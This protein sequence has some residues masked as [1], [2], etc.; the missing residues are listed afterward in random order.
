MNPAQAPHS[1]PI[2]LLDQSPAQ[3]HPAFLL[4]SHRWE[5]ERQGT[6]TL[7]RPQVTDPFDHEHLNKVNQHAGIPGRSIADFTRQLAIEVHSSVRL[8][9]KSHPLAALESDNNHTISEV[10]QKL[11]GPV[12]VLSQDEIRSRNQHLAQQGINL[13]L[14]DFPLEIKDPVKA[15]VMAVTLRAL[16][17]TTL[18]AID[19]EPTHVGAKLAHYLPILKDHIVTS[20]QLDPNRRNLL[21]T[22]LDGAIYRARVKVPGYVDQVALSRAKQEQEKLGI[23]S[24]KTALAQT[25]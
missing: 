6:V 15:H 1:S 23:P 13:S 17:A 19:G 12:R 7:L 25:A 14:P 2:T 11:S 18:M 16:H 20:L 8:F 9:E 3:L 4:G 10:L 5:Q 21:N 22:A 24:E